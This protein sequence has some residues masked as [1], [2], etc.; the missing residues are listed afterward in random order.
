MRKIKY[1]SYVEF[2]DGA[3]EHNYGFFDADTNEFLFDVR[4]CGAYGPN[5][6]EPIAD[7]IVELME[8]MG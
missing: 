6:F 7:A 2:D 8:K 3:M 1:E 5:Q 4:L